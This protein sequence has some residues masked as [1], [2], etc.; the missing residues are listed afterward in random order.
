MAAPLRLLPLVVAL[1]LASG[2]AACAGAPGRPTG[3]PPEYEQ[4]PVPDFMVADA[5]S[6]SE[7]GPDPR[8]M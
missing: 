5:G 6:V 8:G 7:A 2:L 4:A 3:P 1:A